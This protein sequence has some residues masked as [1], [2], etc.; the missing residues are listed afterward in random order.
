LA[1]SWLT[2]VLARLTAVLAG[3]TAV[4]AGL[5]AVLTRLPRVLTARTVAGL[6]PVPRLTRVRPGLS[7]V[8]TWVLTVWPVALLGLGLAT[9][10]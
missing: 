6:L 8:L 3:L 1:R 7:G 2:R 5:A 10:Q 9:A 4:L